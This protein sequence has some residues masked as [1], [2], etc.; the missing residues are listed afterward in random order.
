MESLFQAL[1]SA[2]EQLRLHQATL[3]ETE[4]E[5]FRMERAIAEKESRLE[6]LQQLNEEGAGLAEGSQ[7]VLKGLNDPERIR[8]ALAGALVA[9]LEVEREFVPR[10]RPRS[11]ATCMRSFC[12]IPVWR[13]KFCNRSRAT[14]SARPRSPCPS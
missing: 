7:A 13:R 8:P 3:S 10:S 12:R 4:T 5:A 2:E 11:G 14:I 1:R 9:G 6:I